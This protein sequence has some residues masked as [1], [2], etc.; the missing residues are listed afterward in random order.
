M[1]TNETG[2]TPA[3]LAAENARLREALADMVRCTEAGDPGNMA[4]AYMQARAIVLPS[5]GHRKA[6]RIGHNV[7][8]ARYT[9]SSHDGVKTH[10]DGSPF[11]DIEVFGSR[12][13][14]DAYVDS[15]HKQGY[16]AE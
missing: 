15:L 4:D 5:S 1:K 6:Y 13:G 16:I 2:K 11:Y 10:K 8:K 12:K 9:V 3:Q 14:R 7:G